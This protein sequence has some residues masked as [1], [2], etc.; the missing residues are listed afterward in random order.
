MAQPVNYVTPH[1]LLPVTSS[2]PQSAGPIS[3]SLTQLE[4]GMQM[5]K[6]SSLVVIASLIAAATGVGVWAASA[7]TNQAVN[8]VDSR[9]AIPV[10]GHR[11]PLLY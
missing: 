5:R 6:I 8:V 7:T 1:A 9:G 10:E 11:H 4:M 3:L 2:R